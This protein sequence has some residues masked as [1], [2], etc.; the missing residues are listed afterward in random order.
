MLSLKQ[1]DFFID[2]LQ[3]P[4]YEFVSNRSQRVNKTLRAR[5]LV[6]DTVEGNTLKPEI[7]DNFGDKNKKIIAEN[8]FIMMKG[9][10]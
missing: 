6:K 3:A 4:F 7:L 8:A 2:S 1:L 5:Q 10:S 9:E